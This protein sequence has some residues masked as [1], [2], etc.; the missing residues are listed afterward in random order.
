MGFSH[1]DWDA[2]MDIDIVVTWVDGGDADWAR[3]KRKWQ[4][5]AG[6]KVDDGA[7]RYRDWGLLKYWFRGVARFAP[8]A[9]K[10]HF[11]TC[12]QRPEW[13][14]PRCPR[15]N[16]VDHAD[17][18]PELYLPTFS[19]HPIEL[20]LHRIEGLAEHFV[21]FNDDMFLLRPVGE[22][23]FFRNGVPVHPARLHAILPVDDANREI[24]NHIYL[25][26]MTAINRNFDSK[27]SIAANKSK[28]L[29]PR[30]KSPKELAMN[31]FNAQHN[32]FVGFGDEHL[33]VPIT[34]STM[35]EVWEKEG[36]LL[37][38]TSLRKF[39]DARDVSQYLFR[40][41]DLA[42]GNFEPIDVRRLGKRYTISSEIEPICDVLRG[43]R[44]PMVCLNDMNEPCT[45]EMYEDIR[46]ALTDAFESVLP[47][48]SEFEI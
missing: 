36:P 32:A 31:L 44:Q 9:R 20:N 34:I 33:P 14:D 19:S 21:Y 24:M 15:L 38:E 30:E 2:L 48:K 37:E 47:E 18:M 22:E 10:V 3:E 40:Y 28:W 11:V 23:L 39:R 4:A 41:W 29:G 1:F 27:A 42:S 12:G 16:L 46:T 43:Q 5:E 25:N 6:A 8:W 26:M 7:E 17:Y 13:L 45:D 35:E